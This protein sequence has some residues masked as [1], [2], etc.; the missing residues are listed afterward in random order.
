MFVKGVGF[1]SVHYMMH[2]VFSFASNNH[3]IQPIALLRLGIVSTGDFSW[4][5]SFLLHVGINSALTLLF[6]TEL[7]L[8]L[9]CILLFAALNLF[10]LF[11]LLYSSL[12]L[13]H[14]HGSHTRNAPG[15]L[16]NAH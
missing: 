13:N 2:A 5:T 6:D 9:I 1:L 4:I 11:I 14:R 8:F 3:D 16:V 15:G 10:L 7:H 12:T